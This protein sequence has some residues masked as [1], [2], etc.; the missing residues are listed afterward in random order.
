MRPCKFHFV[1]LSSEFRRNRSECLSKIQH[2]NVPAACK[3]KE[4]SK[5]TVLQD[6][7][8]TVMAT[9]TSAIYY[10]IPPSFPLLYR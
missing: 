5:Y 8:P 2:Q 1:K 3:A 9:F 4:H 10:S 6:N 7:T